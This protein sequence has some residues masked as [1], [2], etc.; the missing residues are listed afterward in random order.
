MTTESGL[1]GK[2]A[3]VTGAGSG[4]GAACARLLARRGAVVALLDIAVDAAER[5]AAEIV[6]D[7]GRGHAY[8]VDVTDPSEVEAT[9]AAV[10]QDLGGLHVLVNNAGLA[11]PMTA[12]ADL[13]DDSWRR[14]MSVNLD[15]VFYCLRAAL[16]VMRPAGAGSVVN[17]SSVLGAVGR[18]NSAAYVATKHAVV[19]L[20][21]GAA[22]DHGADGIRVNAVGPGFVRTP[23]LESRH[24]DEGL[25]ALA[26]SWPLRR[27]GFP[28]EVAEVVAWLAGD[29]ASY[30]TGAY[31]PVDGGYLA[32]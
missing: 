13:D 9:F 31:V 24:T 27:V 28:E 8:R 3:V 15:G 32:V 20:T 17:M 26:A 11:L 7:G 4:I 1:A 29:A 2:V 18:E 14:V 25:A 10:V 21:R 22:I 16:R 30:V 6:A 12:L 5:V 23:L 19:G